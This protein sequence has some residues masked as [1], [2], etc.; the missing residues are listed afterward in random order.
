M[1]YTLTQLKD[2]YSLWQDLSL[3]PI[4]CDWCNIQFEIKYGTLYNIIRRNADGVYCCRTH[5][6]AARAKNT[7]TK[8]EKQGG[9]LCKRCGEFKTLEN[10]WTL[11]NPPFYRSECKRCRNFKPARKYSYYKNSAINQ[12]FIFDLTLDEFLSFWGKEC[13]YCGLEVKNV[14]LDLIISA[15]G[16]K[17]NNCISCCSDCKKFKGILEQEQFIKKC[18]LI[19]SHVKENGEF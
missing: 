9:K 18:N 10:F 8:F 14:G 4:I 5:A 11:P 12:G 13:F 6:G 19:V 15:D 7:Q 17:I 1:M 2:D 16:Y 3:I